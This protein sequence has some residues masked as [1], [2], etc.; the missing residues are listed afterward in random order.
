M[1]RPIKPPVRPDGSPHFYGRRKTHK[2]RPNRQQLVDERL[3]KWR[4]D[5]SGTV[6]YPECFGRA[7]SSVELE[8]GFGAGEH[9]SALAQANPNTDFIGCEPFINGVAALLAD[10]DKHNI[11]NV[12]IFD[13]D[14]R[15]LLPALPPG[16]LSRIYVLYPDPWPKTRHHRRRFVQR[17]TLDLLTRAA[18]PE[19]EFIFASDHMGYIAWTLAQVRRHGGWQWTAKGPED[20]R[21][22][23][24]DWVPTRY[25]RKA[26]K[27]GDHPAYLVFRKRS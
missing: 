25:E 10:V 20:W 9:L 22:P 2:L 12:R 14:A 8:I 16:G 19:A 7:A 11:A 5:V 26:L 1:A 24:P 27:K 15:L 3:P 21:T 13:D 18:G 23:P 6:S 17:D 4:I